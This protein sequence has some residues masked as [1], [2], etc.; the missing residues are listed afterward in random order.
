MTSRQQAMFDA[1]TTV[2]EGSPYRVSPTAKGFDVELD[3]ANRTWWTF[4]MEHHVTQTSTLHVTFPEQR[5]Y[6]VEEELHT[7]TWNAGMPV[8]GVLAADYSN[9]VWVGT[10][11]TVAMGETWVRGGEPVSDVIH[12]PQQLRRVIQQAADSVHLSPVGSLNTIIGIA[13]G[14]FG[15]LVAIAGIVLAIILGP[16]S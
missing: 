1:V 7:V 10:R 14:I 13:A 9:S 4:L 8:L 12:G 6:A 11:S 15:G 16:A 3:V 5:R 2:L